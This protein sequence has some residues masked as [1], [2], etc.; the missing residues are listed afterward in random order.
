M[1]DYSFGNYICALRTG[2]GLS[3][4]QLGTLVGVTDKAVSKWENG[5]AKPRMATMR[6]LADVLGVGIGELLSCEK[7]S[8]IYAR[9]ELDFMNTRL[10]KQAYKKLTMYGDNP[11]AQCL[12]RLAAE[13][14]ALEATDAIQGFAVLGKMMEEAKRRNDIIIVSAVETDSF[15]AWLMGATLVNPLPPH[16]RCPQC[17]HTK[18]VPSAADGFDLPPRKCACGSDYIRDG[19]NLPYE[20]F[21]LGM[22]KI[23]CIDVCI[24]ADFEP[25]AA[26]ILQDF[27]RNVADILP[28]KLMGDE[29]DVWEKKYVV[30]PPDKPRPQ[31]AEDGFWHASLE[32]F[33]KWSQGVF[34]YTLKYNSK[35]EKVHSLQKATDAQLPDPLT[36]TNPVMAT[37]LLEKRRQES[38]DPQWVQHALERNYEIPPC[39]AREMPQAGAVDFTLLIQ[40]DSLGHATGAWTDNA[41]KLIQD[42]VVDVRDVP[43]AREDV[44]AM[45]HTALRKQNISDSG[46]ALQIMEQTRRG[47]YAHGGMPKHIEQF[48]KSAKLP[49]WLPGY[50]SKILY[51][52]PKGH[53]IAHLQLDLILEWFRMNYPTEFA[54]Q[55]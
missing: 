52:F 43:A 7:P 42:G 41:G 30:L 28:V 31:L 21:A 39:I 5:N 23:P 33:W 47:R 22:H 12:S 9:E 11:P 18:F 54:E 25:V 44:W 6:R 49:D 15:A 29:G 20:G 50:L 48:L 4:F 13:E 27:Y 10:W 3:Q 46:L 14:A 34:Y 26:E 55:K 16:Y 1:K 45:I 24:S 35:L 32:E 36:L 8:I 19:H 53:I 2:L 17:G 40:I 51:L 37:A 38:L